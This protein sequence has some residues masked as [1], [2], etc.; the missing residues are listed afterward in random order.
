MPE[1][2]MTLPTKTQMPAYPL[3]THRMIK[4]TFLAS[5]GSNSILS[6]PKLYRPLINVAQDISNN[7]YSTPIH[8]RVFL[9]L[10]Q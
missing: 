7:L 3:F 9:T 2:P 6:A 1:M 5:A 8:L 10:L 4:S